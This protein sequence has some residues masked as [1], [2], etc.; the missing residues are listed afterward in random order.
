MNRSACDSAC[1][2]A[3]HMIVNRKHNIRTYTYV[4]LRMMLKAKLIMIDRMG[5]VA[6]LY[7]QAR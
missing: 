3:Y 4:L 5:R 1:D 6:Q 7:T 2:N